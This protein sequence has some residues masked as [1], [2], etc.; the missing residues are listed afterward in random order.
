MTKQGQNN[1]KTRTKQGQNKDKTRTKEGQ[2]KDKTRTK[3]EKKKMS[4][5]GWQLTVSDVAVDSK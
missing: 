2:N 1:G 5:S 3:P 4:E